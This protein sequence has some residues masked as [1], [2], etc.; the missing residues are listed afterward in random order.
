MQTTMLKGFYLLTMN[1]IFISWSATDAFVQ[2]QT[3]KSIQIINPLQ[4]KRNALVEI[5]YDM[6][7]KNF[8]WIKEKKFK[9]INATTKAETPYQLEYKG[10]EQPVNVLISVNI[11]GGASLKLN[12]KDGNPAILKSKTFAR[13]VPERFDD[14]A[15]E[16]DKVAFRMYGQALESRRDNA[17]GIDVW[18]KRTSE[19]IINKWYKSG[20]Y[21]SDHGEGMD[22][23]GVGNS[24]GA[25]DI[26]PYIKDTIYFTNNYKSWKVL[27]NGPLR[28]TFQLSYP[29]R[30]VSNILVTVVKTISIDA[31]SQLNKIEAMFAYQGNTDL[32]VAIG[33]VKRNTP[34]GAVLLNEQDGIIA[35][36]E[37]ES[38]QNGVTG[39]GCLMTSAIISM[40]IAKGHLLVVS[41]AKPS[42][43][44]IY[45][46][47][48]A[49]NKAGLIKNSQDWINYLSE[50]K[51]DLSTPLNVKIN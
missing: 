22:F 23:Y 45:Y 12:V 48:A 25:G 3:R 20:D 4:N 7:L 47:G 37:P 49:W 32:P 6:F 29:T 51:A 19:L 24:L 50:F 42:Q 17:Y 14:F 40:K 36:W 33:I 15:W 34:G 46:T 11:G 30:N 2:S 28:S 10:N 41:K 26:A 38:P 39:L 16:N 8:P 35:Y 31:G 5:P 21:H 43:P 1:L 18:S 27:D 13:F 9:L 44:F